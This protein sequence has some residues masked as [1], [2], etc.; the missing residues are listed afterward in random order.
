MPENQPNQALICRPVILFQSCV[1]SSRRRP[2][3]RKEPHVPLDR[4]SG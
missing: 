1:R 4:L 2:D 3:P